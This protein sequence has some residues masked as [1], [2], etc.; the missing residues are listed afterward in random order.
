M[1]LNVKSKGT[2]MINA[3]KK[4][5]LVLTFIS[6]MQGCGSDSSGGPGGSR[7]SIGQTGSMAR[8]AIVGD[9]LYLLSSRKTLVGDPTRPRARV[10]T[11]MIFAFSLE[12]P[13]Q[14]VQVSATP[15]SVEQPETLVTDGSRLFVGAQTG[16]SIF[17]LEA[18]ESPVERGTLRHVRSCDP[19]VTKGDLAFVTLR[20][21][22]ICGRGSNQLLIV[23]IADIENPKTINTFPM[24]S[25]WG[26]GVMHDRAYIC[27]GANGL[28]VL[29]VK[30][31]H[32]IKAITGG[33]D[34][35]CFDVIAMESRLITTGAL[36]ISQYR[37]ETESDRPE[38]L[39]RIEAKPEST[40]LGV[41]R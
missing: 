14:P 30:D 7:A 8:F 21:G 35:F 12:N 31:P 33:S 25:P 24:S 1:I 22:G 18:P 5:L 23:N 40:A 15:I 36:G 39:S 28:R 19:V 20:S 37:I 27:D 17:D 3:A 29:D 26:L 11:P 16:M 2:K 34:D 41:E 4:S 6:L 32:D 10:T 38:R 13:E 9:H